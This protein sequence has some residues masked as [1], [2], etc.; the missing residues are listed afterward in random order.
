MRNYKQ[1]DSHYKMTQ[2]I[3]NKRQATST[4]GKFT[5]FNF[6]DFCGD[7]A[8]RALRPSCQ[9]PDGPPG[10]Q[11]TTNP[12]KWLQAMVRGQSRSLSAS[13][14]ARCSSHARKIAQKENLREVFLFKFMP[15]Q[16]I[17]PTWR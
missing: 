6:A 11:L 3:D 1:R 17:S 16:E 9:D 15:A 4:R 13:I 2:A 8:R 7:V 10:I 5:E 14:S 12:A